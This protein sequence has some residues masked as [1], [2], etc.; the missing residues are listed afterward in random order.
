MGPHRIGVFIVRSMGIQGTVLS[1]CMCMLGGGQE[2]KK[3]TGL[4][5]DRLSFSKI[6]FYCQDL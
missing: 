6:T 2:C 4:V 5:D 3:G 1:V